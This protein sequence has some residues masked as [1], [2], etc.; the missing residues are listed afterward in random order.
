MIPVV[1]DAEALKQRY[2][3][4][5][6]KS[7]AREYIVKAVLDVLLPD[8]FTAEITGLGAG[9]DEYIEG[10][11]SSILDAFDITIYYMDR[12]C[13][14]VEV[15]GVSSPQD[16]KPKLGYCV[17]S[18]KLHKAGK[19]NVEPMTWIAFVIDSEPTIL[20]KS[21]NAFNGLSVRPQKLYEDEREVYCLP[22]SRWK[23]YSDFER[24][25]RL[26]GPSYANYLEKIAE[27]VAPW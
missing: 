19:Y 18:W 17:G 5:W 23:R 20:W 21:I 6:R 2:Q 24:W 4:K 3:G 15:T 10:S 8:G 26:Y 7:N 25:L 9:S 27:G 12:P 13:A 1:L 16:A 22:R 11:Y 14:F